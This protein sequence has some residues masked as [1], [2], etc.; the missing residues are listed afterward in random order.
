MQMLDFYARL[1][2]Q[3]NRNYRFKNEILYYA[4]TRTNL[5]KIKYLFMAGL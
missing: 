4:K 5:N 1:T 2:K 3:T